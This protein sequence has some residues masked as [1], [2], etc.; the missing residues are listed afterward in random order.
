MALLNFPPSPNN[1][2]LYPTNPL[3]G[4][5]QYRWDATNATWVLLGPPSGVTPGC[6]GGSTNVPTFCVDTQGRITSAV[7]VPTNAPVIVPAPTTSTDP[8]NSG[9]IAFGPG[10]FYFFDGTQWLQIA[11]TV[12]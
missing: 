8:G 1:G 5:N 3:P 6:Y 9:E 11:G 2:D 10:F 12:F 4:E 7:N